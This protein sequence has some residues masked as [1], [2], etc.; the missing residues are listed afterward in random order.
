MKKGQRVRPIEL[1]EDDAHLNPGTIT[2]DW[3]G[4]PNEMIR[5]LHDNGKIY[6][7]TKDQ[8]ILI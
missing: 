4:N 3:S 5:V 1:P 8:L 7:H 2:Q 6:W